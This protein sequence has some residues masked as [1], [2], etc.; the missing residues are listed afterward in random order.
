MV[1]AMPEVPPDLP[2]APLD[3]QHSQ[4]ERSFSEREGMF[5]VAPSAPGRAAVA[6]FEQ[7][8]LRRVLELGSGQGRDTLFFAQ[9]GLKVVAVDYSESGLAAIRRRADAQEIAGGATAVRH[10]VREP[11]PFAPQAFDAVYSHMLYCMALTSDELER[12]SA[13]VLR[14]LRPGG[15]NVYTVRHVGD[16]HYGAGVHRGEGMY[17]VGG[18]VVH[19]FTRELVQRL[20]HGFE[21]LGI[22]EF[23]EGGLPRKLF[24]VTLRKLVPQ[25]GAANLGVKL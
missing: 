18:F 15:I 12:L 14:V 16:S 4:W 23:E 7:E 25:M 19:F 9:S 13:E 22:E 24:R 17:E 5:G 3:A 10:D 1:K 8:G 21:I 20:A 2:R 11:L 6:L